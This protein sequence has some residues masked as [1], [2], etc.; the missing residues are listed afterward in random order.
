MTAAVVNHMRSKDFGAYDIVR[1]TDQHI[2][3]NAS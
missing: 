1:V 2:A 3:S